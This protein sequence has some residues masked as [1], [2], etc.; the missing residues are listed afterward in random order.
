M[1][2][3]SASDLMDK[4]RDQWIVSYDIPR[5]SKLIKRIKIKKNTDRISEWAP[6][7]RTLPPGTPFEGPWQNEKTPYMIEPADEL[8]PDS[9]TE[10]VTLMKMVQG[11][12]TAG[13]AENKIGYTIDVDPQPL[14]YVTATEDLATEWSEQRLGPMLELCG[15]DKRL[16]GASMAKGTRSTGNKVHSKSFPGGHI[17][18]ASYNQVALLRSLSF[19]TV[20]FDEVDTAPISVKQEGDPRKLGDARTTAYERRKKI[21][22]IS[23]PLDKLTSRV[24]KAFLEGDQRYYNIPCPHCSELITMELLDESYNCKLEYEFANEAKT[25]V[26]EKSVF[27][28]CPKCA[29]EIRNYHKTGIYDNYKLCK[30]V[31]TNEAEAMPRNKSYNINALYCPPGM[32]SFETLAQANDK[33]VILDCKK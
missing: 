6:K 12:A 24:Y 32:I 9:P 2:F 33:A 29:G 1:A 10:V 30:W 7:N 8:S 4:Q 13:S 17:L 23:T 16:G 28:P 18:I 3:S 19:Q 22:I 31:P 26:D 21:L 27:Y 20:I 11:G 5:I 14:L 25:I 15:L